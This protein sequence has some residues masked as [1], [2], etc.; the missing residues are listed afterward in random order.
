MNKFYLKLVARQLKRPK[1]FLGNIV[2]NK[3]QR[4]NRAVYDWMLTLIDVTT[5]KNVLEIGYGTGEVLNRLA[6][7]NNDTCLYGIDFSKVM[8]AKALKVNNSFIKQNRMHLDY[9]DF[10]NYNP[11]VKFDVAYNMN[12]IYFWKDL[13]I[14]FS[15][16]CSVLNHDASAYFYF[17]APDDLIK[18][19]VGTTATFNKYTPD[20]V[21]N[22]LH[23]CGFSKTELNQK[24][25]YS[26]TG[27]CVKASK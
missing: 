7:S 11:D 9:G 13:E 17:T 18:L 24:T 25:I 21:R 22:S 26:F 14:Y 19:G 15:K 27:Y 2:A 8:Y 3:M 12:V 5:A 10:L 23:S 4:G 20:D 6:A 1:G 16:I